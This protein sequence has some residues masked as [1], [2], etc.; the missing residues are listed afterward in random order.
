MVGSRK[1]G[2]Q[3]TEVNS[4]KPPRQRRFVFTPGKAARDH[5]DLSTVV[6]RYITVG[7]CFEI[8]AEL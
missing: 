3:F 5:F 8:L 2:A 7:V 6:S 1:S 4:V